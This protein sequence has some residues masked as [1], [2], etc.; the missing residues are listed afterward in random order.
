[1]KKFGGI[2][3]AGGNATRLSP[4]TLVVNKHFLPVFDKP[5]IYYSLSILLLSGITEITFVCKKEDIER[6][7]LIIGDE[8]YLGINLNFSIQEQPI[9][10]PDGIAKGFANSN[11]ENNLVVLGDNFIHGSNF[12]DNLKNDLLKF[13][14]KCSIYTQ[15]LSNQNNFGVVELDENGNLI[16]L[17]EKPKENKN[18][19]ST[20]IG[21]YKFTNIFEEAFKQISPSIRGE[22]EIVD[23]LNYINKLDQLDVA[24][25]G[26]GT[27]WFDMGTN[28]DLYNSSNFIRSLQSKQHQ[29]ICSPHEIALN[30]NLISREVFEEFLL[31]S[32]ESDYIKNLKKII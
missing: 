19:Y 15:K 11:F 13:P 28:E 6:F 32:V 25:L 22:Y 17:I 18:N 10:L 21:L 30:K 8:K 31:T 29:M 9:G 7:K 24:N 4:T 27:T 12:F 26:R 23:V 16:N 14:D 3:L 20:I 5:M 1:M 2:V